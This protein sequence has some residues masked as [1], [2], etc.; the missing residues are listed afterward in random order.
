MRTLFH[1]MIL[2]VAL[3]IL[4]TGCAAKEPDISFDSSI[5]LKVLYSD[6]RSFYKDYGNYINM[7]FPNIAFKVISIAPLYTSDRPLV[8]TLPELVAKE[9]P[10]LLFLNAYQQQILYEDEA[11]LPL[12]QELGQASLDQMPLGVK[13]VL[14]LQGNG[15]GEIYGIA[16]SFSTEA[17][18]Y[19][20][21]EF[22]RLG[23]SLP[24]E[25]MNWEDTIRLARRFANSETAGLYLVNPDPALLFTKIGLSEG[26]T[27]LNKDN[28]EI[29]FHTEG[30]EQVL[31]S[32]KSLYDEKAIHT[33]ASNSDRFISGSAAMTIGRES[34]LEQL[35]SAD[36]SFQWGVLPFP[37]SDPAAAPID[38][39]HVIAV[40][41]DSIQAKDAV[42][43]I[44]HILNGTSKILDRQA[45]A[46]PASMSSAIASD[47]S[48]PFHFM[49][50]KH[51]KTHL[52][53]SDE[54]TMSFSEHFHQ[55]FF[56]Y[57]SDTIRKVINGDI[58]L[59]AGLQQIEQF[60]N[61]QLQLETAR[62]A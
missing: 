22:E 52:N 31:L 33:A 2:A 10:D 50:T 45:G 8:E 26:L 27:Y 30:W 39:M 12:Q 35:V 53:R 48:H 38:L 14:E 55:Q 36:V 56:T 62:R 32:V 6:K 5:E 7:E 28:T 61:Q 24:E 43:V 59:E 21:N 25:T 44:Q 29:K 37:S 16:A 42:K 46:L 15:T 23:I 17:L 20:K 54:Q 40:H 47:A 34:Y 51:A 60:G 1:K 18:Y 9:T 57:L 19:N 11:L 41:K 49:Y 3:L 58:E 4:F 13:E